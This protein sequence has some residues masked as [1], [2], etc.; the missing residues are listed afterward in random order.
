MIIEH[1]SDTHGKHNKMNGA[2]PVVPDV[3]IFSGD[4]SSAGERW[5]VEDFLEWFAQRPAE[6]HILI[7]GNHDLSFD[8]YRGSNNGDTPLWLKDALK[9]FESSGSNYYLEN[10]GIVID[11]VLFWGSPITPWFYGEYWAFNKHRSENEIGA[12]W[13]QIPAATDVLI[14]H[15]P[16]YG[17]RDRTIINPQLVGCEYLLRRIREVKPLLNLFG[18]IHEGYGHEQDE[19]SHYFNGSILDL[20]YEITNEPWLLDVNFTEKE[21]KIL[22]H[23][24]T[25]Q[26]TVRGGT[27][28]SV[29]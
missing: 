23:V 3:S 28:G 26:A 24:R 4:L 10:S 9:E 11:K 7:A 8:P 20:S 13:K 29:L 22:N 6:H 14:T 16:P 25:E 18:H 2:M 15:G 17:K 5:Q 27:T 12:I 19:H 1:F 21:V